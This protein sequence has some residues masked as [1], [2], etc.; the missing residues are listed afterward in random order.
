MEQHDA[1]EIRVLQTR[2]GEAKFYVYLILTQSVCLI[3]R[4]A[5]ENTLNF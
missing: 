5:R 1:G 2:K 3:N 4:N